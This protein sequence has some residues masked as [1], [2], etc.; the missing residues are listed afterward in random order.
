MH[1]QQGLQYSVCLSV[2]VCVSE[3]VSSLTATLLTHAQVQR[4]IRIESKCGTEDF[5]LMDS[6]KNTLFKSYGVIW[7]PQRTLTVSTESTCRYI[8]RF[9]ITTG[10]YW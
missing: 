10:D 4:K 2:C 9:L 5:W 1:A 8:R 7:S 3:S 6:A